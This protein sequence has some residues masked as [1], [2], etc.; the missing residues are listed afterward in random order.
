MN[1]VTI[2]IP[3]FNGERY[4]ASCIDS[5][6][7]QSIKDFDVIL[8]DD[9]S[10]DNSLKLVEENYKYVKCIASDKNNGFCASVNLGIKNS[11]TP[12]VILLN[13]DTVAD[14]FFVEEMLKSIKSFK[15]AFSCSACM[16]QFNDRDIIDDA[17]DLYNA[18]GWARARGK[19][20]YYANYQKKKKIFASCGGAAIYKKDVFEEI[21][22]FDERH[23]AYLEDIDVGYRSKINGYINY[24]Q[25]NAIIYHIGSGTS[26]S[27]YN[28]FKIKHSSRNSVYLIYKNMP[29]LQII[30]NMIPIFIGFFVKYLFFLKKGYG[31]LYINGLCEGLK[32]SNRE[33]KVRFRIKNLFNYIKI[34]FELW[35]NIFRIC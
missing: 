23:F 13:N 18:L 9:G 2:V 6:Q 1:E 5:L 35:V 4:L 32:M 10:R 31:K 20:K 26:G 27:R 16:R 7:N 25:P 8:V 14:E 29:V 3:N 24:Y 34:Q 12:Y 17:G 30:I 15:K 28:D 19:D 33:N 11:V 21:G 22:Y